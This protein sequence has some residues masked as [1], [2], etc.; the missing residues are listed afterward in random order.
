MTLGAGGGPLDTHGFDGELLGVVD[1]PGGLTKT[2]AGT[3]VLDGTN[4]YTGGTGRRRHVDAG[5]RLSGT[6]SVQ[7]SVAVSAGGT[8]TGQGTVGGDLL[9]GAGGVV[10][11]G[12]GLSDSS[13]QI[14][15]AALPPSLGTLK[16]L[17][18]LKRWSRHPGDRGHPHAL[19]PFLSVGGQARLN[20]RNP[21]L[22]NDP[23]G[24]IDEPEANGR[25]GA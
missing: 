12:V 25:R 6:A 23:V 17:G 8:L 13:G 7:G 15:P 14:L 5:R 4:T 11:P 21:V 22:L 19:L 10:L 3:L 1:G 24:D 9:N 16:V 20:V 2:G 18:R